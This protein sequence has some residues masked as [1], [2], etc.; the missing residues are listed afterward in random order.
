MPLRRLLL[1]A[2]LLG[3]NKKHLR[4]A[5]PRLVGFAF[6]HITAKVHID[7]RFEDNELNALETL[8]FPKLAKGGVCL[9]IGSNIGNHAVA[10]ADHV[11][12]VHAFEPNPNVFK[13]LQ[14]NAGLK[15]NIHAHEIGCSSGTAEIEVIENRI[16]T[17]GSGVGVAGNEFAGDTVTFKVAP[18]DSLAVLPS[19][20]R[21]TFVKMDVEGHE[22]DAIKGAA[23]TFRKHRPVIAI[24]VGRNTVSNG[25]NAALDELKNLGYAHFYEIP[26]AYGLHRLNR[27][28]GTKIVPVE[29]LDKRNYPL[30]LASME[31][32]L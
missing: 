2:L 31:P 6:D 9:D 24:E 10:C 26:R 30:F 3:Q 27:G 23:E 29:R 8:L 18:L 7:G 16:N 5:R 32:I 11:S 21:V 12:A 28:G 25:S 15:G 20:A 14:I 17:G 1:K 4:Q 19:D 13:L 22:A